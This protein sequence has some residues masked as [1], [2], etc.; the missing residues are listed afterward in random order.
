MKKLIVAIIITI[1]AIVALIAGYIYMSQGNVQ[2]NILKEELEEIVKID[3]T[4]QDIPSNI[5]TNRSYG[6]VEKTVKNYLS[7]VRDI[8]LEIEDYCNEEAMSNILSIE[9]IKQDKQELSVVKEELNKYKLNLEQEVNNFEN[10]LEK[11]TIMEAIEDENVIG[12]YKNIYENIMFNEA[13]Q[14]N[15]QL[16]KQEVVSSQEKS[17]EKLK[18]MD[19]VVKFLIDNNNYW[20][21]DEERQKIQFTN[22]K[23]LTEWIALFNETI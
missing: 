1:M 17:Q 21:I 9:N 18:D 23:K 12:Y 20:D 11:N 2:A 8:Y 15:L 16:A 22:V 7:N 10:L 4:S 5:K 14:A 3:I 6:I 19:K 13:L